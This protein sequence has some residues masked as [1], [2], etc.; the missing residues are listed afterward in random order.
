MP[1]SAVSID[2]RDPRFDTLK[3]GQ[4]LR[5]PANDAEAASRILMCSDADEAAEALQRVVSSGLRPTVRSGGHCYEDFVVNNPHGVIL[6]LSLDNTV[7]AEPGGRPLRIASGAVLGEI[8]QTLYKRFGLT[9]PAGSCFSVGAGG[10]ISGGGY[11]LLSRLHGLTCDWITAVDIL[12]VNQQGSVQNL[13]VDPSNHPDLLRACRG[14]GGGNFGLITSFRFDTLPTAPREVAEASISFP[15]SSLDEVTFSKLLATFGEYCETRGQDR[16]TWGLFGL[17]SIGPANG[18]AGRIGVGVQ[19]CNP[20]GTAS[21]LS[22]LHEF[23][24]RFAAFN[25][26]YGSQQSP[27]AH[28]PPADWIGRRSWFDAT[29]GGGGWGVGSRAK[30]KS[31]YMKQSFTAA[32]SAAIFKYFNSPEIDAQGSVL[33]I[34]SYGGAINNHARLADTSVAQRSSIMKLQ[35]QS[36]WRDASMDA[37]RLKFMDD[38]Y[39]AVYTGTHVPEQ[40]QETPFGPRYEGCYMNYADADMLRYPHWPQLFYGNGEL[41]PFL[42]KVKQRYDPNNIF[43][44]AMSIR[45]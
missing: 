36:Y 5:F 38:C 24:A 6:D 25:P 34:D 13:R 15:W 7:D 40:Y 39:R 30:Y 18:G 17:M 37:H 42:Q 8:Y 11:G 28:T 3:K 14:A 43:H 45:T 1:S 22:V 21:D 29:L 31:A 4:N 9:I 35:W 19:F 23:F 12:T 16:E 32:E 26:V 41:Y 44:S 2:R 27:G 10:H 33:V 20:D